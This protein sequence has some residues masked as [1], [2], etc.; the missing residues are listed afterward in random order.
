MR[1]LYTLKISRL[2]KFRSFENDPNW[3]KYASFNSFPSDTRVNFGTK[4]VTHN[5]GS[6]QKARWRYMERPEN[7]PRSFASKLFT[8]RK[9]GRQT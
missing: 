5:S 4:C 3:L 2:K 1:H 6:R 9:L 7:R 8:L